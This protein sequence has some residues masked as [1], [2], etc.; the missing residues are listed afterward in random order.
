MNFLLLK[1]IVI[2]LIMASERCQNFIDKAKLVN[3]DKYKY[4]YDLVEYKNAK[5]KV[6]IKCSILKKQRSIRK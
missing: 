3:G 4:N 2:K 6:K 5:T 1:R